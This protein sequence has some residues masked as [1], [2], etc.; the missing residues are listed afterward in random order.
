MDYGGS[1]LA[2]R[3]R[4]L[5]LDQLLTLQEL[6]LTKVQYGMQFLADRCQE[7]GEPLSEEAEQEYMRPLYKI[8]DSRKD[9]VLRDE[10]LGRWL[11]NKL[12]KVRRF[13]LVPPQKL[14]EILNG[15]QLPFEELRKQLEDITFGQTQQQISQRASEQTASAAGR[16]AVEASLSTDVRAGQADRT[17]SSPKGSSSP[18]ASVEHGQPA[19]VERSAALASRDSGASGGPEPSERLDLAGRADAFAFAGAGGASW[20]VPAA[21]HQVPEI[22]VSPLTSGSYGDSETFSAAEASASLGMLPPP[23]SGA[24]R[25][26][27]FSG[28]SAKPDSAEVSARFWTPP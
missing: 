24:A 12:S 25:P 27:T 13:G 22:H 14:T 9:H 21:S 28:Q 10:I 8:S 6:A 7:E 16:Q 20:S 5:K 18:E 2:P 19:G 4:W 3:E 15:P 26:M 23:D 1:S 17:S 11:V